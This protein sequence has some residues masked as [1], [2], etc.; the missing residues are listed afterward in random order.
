MHGDDDAT[1]LFEPLPDACQAL[2]IGNGSS[3]LGPKSANLAG[4]CRWLF[5]APLCEAEPCFGDP[6]LLGLCV[7]FALWPLFNSS[8]VYDVYRHISTGFD[9]EKEFR[10]DSTFFDIRQRC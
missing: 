9:S 7:F 10:Q 8:T 6:L 4:F 5:P 2:P 1:F 3:D